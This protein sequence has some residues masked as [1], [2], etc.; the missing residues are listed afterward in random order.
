MRKTLLALALLLVSSLLVALPSLQATAQ[1]HRVT[2]KVT[3]QDGS[4]LPG[5]TIQIKGTSSGT[6]TDANGQY[7]L[8]APDKATLIFRGVGFREENI[9]VGPR[10]TL[11]V[12]M[13]AITSQLNE[14]VVTAFGIKRA[15]RS[16]GYATASVD[17]KELNNGNPVNLQTGLTGRI[18]GLQINE[19]N[20]GVNPSFRVVLRGE[21]HITADNQ[22]LIVLD[23]M[24]VTSDVL[25]TLNP[26][27]IANVSVLKGASASALYG[28]EAS[29]G[30]III[31]TKHGTSSGKPR[32]TVS[33][34]IQFQ[35]LSYYPKFQTGFGANGGEASV[36]YGYNGQF[37]WG[38]DPYT[39]QSGYI[40]YENESYG[41]PF[42]GQDYVVG[43]P[44]ANGQLLKLPYKAASKP[45][46]VAFAQTGKTFQNEV[47]YSA[48][49]NKNNFFLSIQDVSV[50]GVIPK[51]ESRRDN[52][53]FGSTKTYG[54]FSAQFDLNYSKN[55]SN[56]VGGDP[57]S[58][59]AL[60]WNLLNLPVNYPI[61][62]FKDWQ[63][64]P[65][66]NPLEGW[67]NAYYTNPW[68]QIDE[69]RDIQDE[70]VLNGTMNLTLQATSWLSLTYK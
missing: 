40:P 17:S 28:S 24:L 63:T 2:G 62:M 16:V 49:D 54:K 20:N 1:E 3:G 9:A 41:T 48:G 47:S 65:F 10:S 26:Q 7:E 30:V 21:R 66:A 15:A 59:S 18:A 42:N 4:P 5:I 13:H 61:Q 31:T 60:V 45:P 67:V 37:Q 46:L 19:V 52:F 34:T 14:L 36:L 57:M 33:S 55:H 25:S 11:D 32:V 6:A 69:S 70:D 39:N 38:T 43:G 58:G 56:T 12:I 64:N 53:R 29:N 51:D 44:L 22:A 68:W 35:Q 8:T 27:D 50:S 23:G